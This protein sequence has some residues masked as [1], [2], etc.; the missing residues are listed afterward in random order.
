MLDDGILVVRASVQHQAPWHHC[1][2]PWYF[3]PMILPSSNRSHGISVQLSNTEKR[4]DSSVQLG[5][6][7]KRLG[8]SVVFRARASS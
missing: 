2:V 1:T 4:L 3:R 5:N 8:S 7:E 6:T